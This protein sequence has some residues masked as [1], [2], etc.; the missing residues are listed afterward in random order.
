MVGQQNL[1]KEN[2]GKGVISNNPFQILEEKGEDEEEG[3][4]RAEFS[5]KPKEGN[6]MELGNGKATEDHI[7][8]ME[9]DGAEDMELGEMD[10]DEN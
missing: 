4:N 10:L 5:E 7:K 1:V 3:R 6:E 2:K 8:E 9:G